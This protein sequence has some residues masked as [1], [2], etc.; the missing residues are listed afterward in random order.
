MP[1]AAAA[2]EAFTVTNSGSFTTDRGDANPGDGTCATSSGD[3]TFIA[4]IEE[5]NADA[6]QDRIEF[7]SSFNPT[8]STD[9]NF[10]FPDNTISI[11]DPVVID[12]RTAPQYDSGTRLGVTLYS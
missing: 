7:S 3:C 2:Q 4:A 11:V 1:G 5:A 6:D 12:G 8:S 10:L 9:H